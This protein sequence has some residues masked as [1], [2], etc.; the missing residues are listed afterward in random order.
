M[1]DIIF[2]PV[3]TD[4]LLAFLRNHLRTHDPEYTAVEKS[5]QEAI[6][7]LKSTLK[8]DCSPLLDAYIAA[9]DARISTC[10]R[11]L[12]W[13]GLH[14]NEACFRDLIQ[15]KFLDLDFEDICQESVLN[16]LLEAVHA[17]DCAQQFNRLLSDAESA[18]AD[19]I[20]EYYC[21][22]ETAGYKLAHYW[23]FRYGDDLLPTVVPGYIPDLAVT[24]TYRWMLQNYLEFD[25][26]V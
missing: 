24:T 9:E 18:Q 12:F 16:S 2:R 15:K 22:L 23:G 8:P 5:C 17:Y 20:T 11:F 10:L 6:Q 4:Y 19:P 14:Q 3:E 21:H 7:S 26:D 13:K 1:N 25:P